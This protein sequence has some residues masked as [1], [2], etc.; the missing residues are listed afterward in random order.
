MC[1]PR[2]RRHGSGAP[3]A[4]GAPSATT[5]GAGGVRPA[6]RECLRRLAV[7]APV[8]REH[9]PVVVRGAFACDERA[10]HVPPHEFRIARCGRAETPR[11]RSLD[12]DALTRLQLVA[13]GDGHL[14][15]APFVVDDL[16]S[17][18]APGP[19]SLDAGRRELRPFGTAHD[20]RRCERLVLAAVTKAAAPLAGPAGVGGKLEAANENGEHRLDHLDRRYREVRGVDGDPETPSRPCI[21]PI[22]LP[23]T[24]YWKE[25]A[26]L[27]DAFQEMPSVP[28]LPPLSAIERSGTKGQSASKQ[29][30]VKRCFID[31]AA[32]TGAGN[33]GSRTL[34]GAADDVDRATHPVGETGLRFGAHKQSTRRRCSCRCRDR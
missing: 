20:D 31:W 9:D 5:T 18:E 33:L 34:P 10:F 30:S 17:G 7:H 16:Y 29:R 6:A 12:A 26:P 24:S 8:G 3:R 11:P 23:N 13:A 19:A 27:T 1:H 21:A 25:R 32:P 28:P 2:R 22:P 15:G 4:H 14:P